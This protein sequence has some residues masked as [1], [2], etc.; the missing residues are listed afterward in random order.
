MP[1]V[2]QAFLQK[3]VLQTPSRLLVAAV[4]IQVFVVLITQA[5]AFRRERPI[6]IL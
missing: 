5:H 6:R 1:P 4:A 2:L 3:T